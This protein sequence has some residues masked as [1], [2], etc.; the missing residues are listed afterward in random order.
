MKLLIWDRKKE[1]KPVGGPT[2][3]LYNLNIYF[4][5]AKREEIFFIDDYLTNT[6]FKNIEKLKRSILKKKKFF[7]FG[8]NREIFNLFQELNLKVIIDKKWLNNYDIIHFHISKE[9]YKNLK[10]IENIK[11][12]IVL[13]SHC[14]QLATQEEFEANPEYFSKFPLEVLEKYKE[15]EYT[16]FKRADYLI[17]PCKEALEPY[18]KDSKMCELLKTKKI[19]YLLTGI[20]EKKEA[21]DKEY[22]KNKYNIPENS[23]IISYV[24]RHN[25]IKGYDILKEFGKIILE[26]YKNVYFIVAGKEDNRIKKLEH[27]RWIECGW[28]KEG[29]KIMKNSDLFILPNRETYFDLIFLEALS[30]NCNIL[31]SN[32]GG[33]KYFKKYN[34]DKIIYFEKENITDMINK[35]EYF[36]KNLKSIKSQN[37][38]REIFLKDFTVEKF[39]ENYLKLME[40]ILQ[41]SKNSEKI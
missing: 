2:G 35:F 10:N 24:G 30:L 6:I 12:L 16:A 19:K 37:T 8:L 3:Y 11:S 41:E 1:L 26:K 15:Y 39:G 14:P 18:N 38:N 17:F 21:E 7:Y 36:Y 40:E 13:T 28:T 20:E 34:S 29:A 25:K 9:L 33:N 22:F 27:E 5:K 32:T 31:C 4:K 23:I